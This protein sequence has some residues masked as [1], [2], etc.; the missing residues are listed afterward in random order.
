ME[1]VT[2]DAL[3]WSVPADLSVAF[4]FCPFLGEV[5]DGVI[6]GLL[7]S[8]DAHPRPLRIVYTYPTEHARLVGNPRI[9]VLDVVSSAWPS[10]NRLAAEV[11]VT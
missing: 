3:S 9:R 7:D 1:V 6:Q 11:I 4:F 10:R 8:V 5:F 2:S